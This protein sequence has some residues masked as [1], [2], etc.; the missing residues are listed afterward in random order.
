MLQLEGSFP[1]LQVQ[2]ALQR[3][4]WPN[5][6]LL[7]MQ[8]EAASKGDSAQAAAAAAYLSSTPHCTTDQH[9]DTVAA[10][11]P[12]PLDRQSIEVALANGAAG[13]TWPAGSSM[14]PVSLPPVAEPWLGSGSS[15]T[16]SRR[17][18]FGCFHTGQAEASQAP[19]GGWWWA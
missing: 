7:Y 19:A 12:P 3:I 10:V 17:W 16:G 1:V 4:D 5:E 9:P 8:Q 6:L 11:A 2:Q 14:S 13:E 15:T 18:S